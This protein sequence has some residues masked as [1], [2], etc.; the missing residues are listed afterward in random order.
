[1][2]RNISKMIRQHGPEFEITPLTYILPEDYK[3]F[4]LDR[5]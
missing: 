5:S 2:W 3:R 4:N 1:M